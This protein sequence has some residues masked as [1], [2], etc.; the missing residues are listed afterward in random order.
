MTK[1]SK[2]ILFVLITALSAWLL[3]WSYRF[4]TARPDSYPF[5]L[6]SPIVHAF[7]SLNYTDGKVE[8]KDTFGRTYSER[9]FDSILPTFYYRQ[10][11]SDGRLPATIEGIP[12]DGRSIQREYFIFRSN[13]THIN[14]VKTPLYPLLEAIPKRVDLEMPD[15]VFRITDRIEFVEMA[16]NRIREEK[17]GHFTRTLQ[18]KG[19][20]FP[21]RIVAGNPTP[22]K[23]YDEGYLITDRNYRLF[24]VKKLR[25]RPY[26]RPVGIPAEVHPQH[27]YVTEYPG[28]HYLG[29]LTDDQNRF[30][31]LESESY[32]LQQLP[33]P[34]FDPETEDMMIIGDAFYWTIRIS[35][36]QSER[37]YAVNPRNYNLQDSLPIPHR[38]QTSAE[39]AQY[40]FPFQL[41]FTSYEDRF[42]TPRISD[43]SCKALILNFGLAVI[44]L[45]TGP[46]KFRSRLKNTPILCILGLFGLIPLF[47][48]KR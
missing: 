34:G 39:I 13:T 27:L 18:E 4:A 20:V 9:Q 16:T 14:T 15:D 45:L 10:L 44:Y 46:G 6:Y 5:T 33:I 43:I 42:V 26:V 31:V 32:K 40:F 19:F 23:D 1:F 36:K 17:S 37:I 12:V 35:G 3:P 30:Y 29:F 22:R 47:L 24:H 11:L 21:A 2:I 38:K 28:R 41:S 7:A 48:R 25:D 8:Y